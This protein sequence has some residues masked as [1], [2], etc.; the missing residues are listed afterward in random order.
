MSASKTY[1]KVWF[2]GSSLSTPRLFENLL[3]S[4]FKHPYLRLHI[5]RY[6]QVASV[7][8]ISFRYSV[9]NGLLIVQG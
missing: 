3:Y 5:I 4:N 7:R 6:V 2:F 1:K 9:Q 8:I